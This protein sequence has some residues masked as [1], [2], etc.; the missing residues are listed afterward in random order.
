V[1][2]QQEGMVE[3]QRGYQAHEGVDHGADTAWTF[4]DIAGID[5]DHG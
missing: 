5:G 4:S 2:Q 3:H 1:T